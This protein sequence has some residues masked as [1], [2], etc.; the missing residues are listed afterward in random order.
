MSEFHRRKLLTN[1]SVLT[2]YKSIV[3][4]AVKTTWE[5]VHCRLVSLPLQCFCSPCFI[6]EGMPHQ[7]LCDCCPAPSILPRSSTLQ[8]PSSLKHKAGTEG[9]EIP[10]HQ[11]DS[12]KTAD[13]T[14]SSEQ[15]NVSNASNGGTITELIVSSSNGSNLNG[16]SWTTYK[17]LLSLRIKYSLETLWSHLVYA[18]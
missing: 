11:H 10:Q 2:F 4:W 1:T 5:V 6:Y 16:S 3:R 17:M 14:S 7:L 9:Q 18:I 13:Y 12:R 15:K 8:F